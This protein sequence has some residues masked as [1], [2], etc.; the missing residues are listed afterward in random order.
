[1]SQ[2]IVDLVFAVL[3]IEATV[4]FFST[5]FKSTARLPLTGDNDCLCSPHVLFDDTWLLESLWGWRFC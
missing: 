5:V 4:L 1:M 2:Y 3:L